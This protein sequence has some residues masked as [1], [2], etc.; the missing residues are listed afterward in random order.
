MKGE[1]SILLESQ[2][3]SLDLPARGKT[4]FALV[5]SVADDTE[6][7]AVEGVMYEL[8]GD[9]T[10]DPTELELPKHGHV[11]LQP[12]EEGLFAVIHHGASYELYLAEQ[13]RA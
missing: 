9:F 3:L 8:G 11:V 13:E 1:Q 10:G 5:A 7:V 4:S 12:T 2:V 6:W